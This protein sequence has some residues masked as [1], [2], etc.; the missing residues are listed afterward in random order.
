MQGQRRIGE[1]GKRGMGDMRICIIVG[2]NVTGSRT[3]VSRRTGAD[4]DQSA[5]SYSFYKVIVMNEKKDKIII[6]YHDGIRVGEVLNH[7]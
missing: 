7:G 2:C 3:T 1:R 4:Y 5:G 6:R